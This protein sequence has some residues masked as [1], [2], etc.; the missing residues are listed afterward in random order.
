MAQRNGRREQKVRQAVILAAGKGQR[1]YPLTTLRPK[2]MLPVGNKPILQYVVEALAQNGVQDI[3][4]VVGYH[5]E[6]IQDYFGS[7]ERFGARIRYA[8][9]EHQLGTGHA[10]LCARDLAE[11]R[12]LVLPGD[13][14]I[15]SSTLRDL[16]LATQ[17]TV[18]VKEAPGRQYGVVLIENGR[19]RGLVEKPMEPVSPWV[20]TGSYL[21]RA[22]I[23]DRLAEELDLP[24]ALHRMVQEGHSVAPLPTQGVWWDAAYPWDLLQL[25]GL[26]LGELEERV[27]GVREPGVVVK[28]RVQVGETSVL[29]ANSYIVGP[30][31]IGEGCEIGPSAAVF[32]YTSIGN[33]VVMDAFTQ[34]RNCIIGSSVQVG[35][36]SV[37]GDTII[38]DGCTIGPRFTAPSGKTVMAGDGEP[39][40]IRMGAIVADNVEI[41]AGVA[42]RPGLL[43]GHG[44]HIREMNHLRED[45][46]EGSLVV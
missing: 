24:A 28:G 22:T 19:V 31:V 39:V 43:I 12:F 5:R 45:I 6:Q 34:V 8:T 10:L 26:A 20:N 2:V 33:N 40:E 27:A 44:A 15:N 38:A 29:R 13:N 30:A 14:I 21:L 41:G 9:Q 36:H 25:N 4:I 3:V 37:L 18:L 46:P 1:L 42:L 11:E 32:P 35:S 16:V 7:G 23:F 17:E